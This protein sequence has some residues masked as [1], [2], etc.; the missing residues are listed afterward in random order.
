LK[1]KLGIL[2][3]VIGA[4]SYAYM[5]VQTAIGTGEGVSLTTFGLWAM[6]A[7]ITV[8]TMIKQ[9]ANPAVPTIFGIGSTATALVL[10]FKGRLFWTGMDTIIAILVVLCV[11]LWKTKGAK[12]A[13]V[14][15]VLAAVIAGVP[16]II[17]TWKTPA[18]SPI[19]PNIGF[20][21]TNTLAFIS[22][23][24]WRLEDRLYCGVNTVVCSLLVIPWFLQ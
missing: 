20:L 4:L 13:L 15:S 17:M 23:K 5:I 8:F 14:L 9:G 2:G 11:L 7:W 19:I 12:W 10:V 24:G 6:L 22:V 3:V 21:I 18:S 16:F 1:K